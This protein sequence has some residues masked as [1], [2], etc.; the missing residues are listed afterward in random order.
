MTQSRLRRTYTTNLRV[1]LCKDT[2]R[3]IKS[4]HQSRTWLISISFWYLAEKEL[5]NCFYN[6]LNLFLFLLRMIKTV[7]MKITNV[8][9]VKSVMPRATVKSVLGNGK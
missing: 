4:K 5:T 3:K 7:A 1:K 9:T 8:I 2:I 6:I